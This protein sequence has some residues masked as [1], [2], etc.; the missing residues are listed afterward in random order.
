MLTLTNKERESF[1]Y[2][3]PNGDKVK[4]V[5]TQLK[6]NQVRILIGEPYNVSILRDMATE[7]TVA[8]PTNFC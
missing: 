6:D 3:L 8:E 1:T 5:I 2:T 4:I 7:S